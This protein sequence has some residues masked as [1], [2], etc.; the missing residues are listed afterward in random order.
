[1]VAR[2]CDHSDGQLHYVELTSIETPQSTVAWRQVP[3]INV[4]RPMHGLHPAIYWLALR[5]A[6]HPIAWSPVVRLSDVVPVYFRVASLSIRSA[7]LPFFFKVS[8]TWHTKYCQIATPS[9]IIQSCEDNRQTL[10][11]ACHMLGLL[12]ACHA[13]N[14]SYTV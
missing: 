4:C 2:A 1:M 11:A 8:Y 14:I 5:L 9:T 6:Y 3:T 13:K 12:W 7:R 10:S